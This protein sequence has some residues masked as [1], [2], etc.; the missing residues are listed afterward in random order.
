VENPAVARWARAAAVEERWVMAGRWAGGEA[1]ARER[2]LAVRWAAESS[3]E[4]TAVA[5]MMHRAAAENSAG[6]RWAGAR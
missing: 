6:A 4:E 2:S 1:A 3:P 5:A